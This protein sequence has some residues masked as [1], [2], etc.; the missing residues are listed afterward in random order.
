MDEDNSGGSGTA[1]HGHDL[2]RKLSGCDNLSN[3]FTLGIYI[4]SF[5][6]FLY[7]CVTYGSKSKERHGKQS[8]KFFLETQQYRD[9]G[10]YR[11]LLSTN[12]SS[13]EQDKKTLLNLKVFLEKHNPYKESV[14]QN[15]HQ[16]DPSPCNWSCITC[17]TVQ[18]FERVTG[19][20]LTGALF[21]GNVFDGF[22]MLT[23]LSSLLLGS[24]SFR[25][26]IPPDLGLCKSLTHLDLSN[27]FLEGTPNLTG[28][29]NLRVV[30]LSVNRLNGSI[31]SA[32]PK[33]CDYLTA[34]NLSTN[35]FTG[36]I[37]DTLDNC[38]N[39]R[40]IDLSENQLVGPV[41]RGFGAM[42]EVFLCCNNFSGYIPEAVFSESCK[43][44]KLDL[45]KNKL[46]GTI[47]GIIS[48]C[49]ELVL[50]DLSE[51]NLTGQIPRQFGLMQK[52]ETLILRQ[53]NLSRDI[54]VELT[55]CKNLSFLDL[56]GNNFGGRIQPIFGELKGLEFLILH[57]NLYE[58]SISAGIFNLSRL[59]SMD[60]SSNNFSGPLP[61]ELGS[62]HS[63]EF[64]FL[65]CNK[66]LG[67]IPGELGQLTKLQV[68]DLSFNLL[69][70]TIP[71]SLG[72]LTSL[73][74]LMLENNTLTGPI[75]SEL[76]KCK[77]LLWLNLA[78][79]QLSGNLPDTLSSMGSNPHE[80]FK[81][82]I[83]FLKPIPRQSGQCLSFKRWIPA[84][85]PPFNFVYDTLNRRSCKHLWENLLT[86]RSL[87]P[88][89]PKQGNGNVFKPIISGYLQLTGNNLSGSIPKSIGKMSYLSLILFAMNSFDGLLPGEI[90]NPPLVSVNVSFN[91]F[92]GFLPIPLGGIKCLQSLDLSHNN[93]NGPIP[94]SF[95]NLNELTKFNISYNR[96]LTGVAPCGGQF[97]TFEEDSYI[98]D[99]L[100]CFQHLPNMR[101]NSTNSRPCGLMKGRPDLVPSVHVNSQKPR[102][103]ML[104][105]SVIA[106][107]VI[108]ICGLLTFSLRKK[109]SRSNPMEL[110]F[111]LLKQNNSGVFS[112]GLNTMH[113]FRGEQFT[114]T[115]ILLATSNFSE[116]HIIGN[117]GFGTVYKGK[118]RNGSTVAIKKLQQKGPE[119]EKE[120]LAEMQTLGNHEFHENLVPLL[121]CCL[122]GTEK[123][124]VYEFMSNGS[125]EDWLHE[126]H[127]GPKRL[128]WPTRY[129][130]AVGTAKGL[131]FLHHDCTPVVIHRDMKASNILLDDSFNPHVTDFGLARCLDVE[132]THVSTVVA[133]TVGYVPPE[134]SQSWRATT[135]GDVYS[136]GVVLLELV[137]G[138][139]PLS[140]REN[141]D[142][143]LVEWVSM[144]ISSGQAAEAIDPVLLV[145]HGE[146]SSQSSTLTHSSPCS[147]ICSSPPS[148][149]VSAKYLQ[150]DQL[151]K[152]LHLGHICTDES[153]ERRP[154]IKRVL[155][156]LESIGDAQLFS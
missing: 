110:E 94:R 42:E 104:V 130:I 32:F 64:V 25:G 20:N 72:N 136:Y 156:I 125:L 81:H 152:F 35:S 102:T 93:F 38:R 119:G 65:A 98:G 77:S 27:N 80:I 88:I 76:G 4:V 36:V 122:F 85:Y 1:L 73:L 21:Q 103:I 108:L 50:L 95:T 150:Q 149:P 135:K 109:V 115:D 154:N 123:L 61:V 28:L 69:S 56:S 51:T 92:S 19:V 82:N 10:S 37:P 133:G 89:C 39:L 53:I 26:E 117:G 127:D 74:W 31:S 148:G 60:F 118:L 79:N 143:N 71:P 90:A 139:K 111:I 68:L 23:A 113:F 107:A 144:L 22:S 105:V 63:L 146:G 11:M 141:G 29:S 155:T 101:T 70:G 137:T 45:S 9:F 116:S 48:N 75:P 16:S 54:P 34:M 43:L 52:L 33:K 140:V 7:L 99:D 58:H 2:R 66:F 121:G 128:D 13:L 3:G 151:I 6:L 15:W 67:N 100:L 106:T 138:K 47:P 84:D 83:K 24:N 57:D 145:E 55:G 96:L 147:S 41:W 124:L 59:I 12:A 78:Y 18:G 120:F 30:D 114:F 132:G 40:F 44:R 17:G 87:F 46:E 129:K 112:P 126:K 14:Y 5:A 8:L 142:G 62:M 91:N 153:P 134:Y 97:S 131:K 49:S 86:G